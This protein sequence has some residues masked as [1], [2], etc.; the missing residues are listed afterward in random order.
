LTSSGTVNKVVTAVAPSA[1]APAPAP[2]KAAAVLKKR[3]PVTH[4][5]IAPRAAA[6][7]EASD[8]T[9]TP[10]L[11]GTNPHGQGTVAVID[12][13]PDPSRPYGG[14]T[15]GASNNEDIVV[16]RS[17]GEQRPDGTY[18]GHITVAALFGNEIVGVDTNP[19]ETK[20]GP[21]NAVQ[22]SLLDALCDG[23]GNQICLSAVTVDSTTTDTGSTNHFGVAHATLGGPTGIDVGAAESDGNI[24]SDGT[25]QT[26]T[27]SSQAA[28]V[29]AGGNA[30]ASVAKSSTTSKACK[31]QAPQQTNQSSVIQLGGT[32]VPLPAAG[33][34]D[35]TADTVTDIPTLL[36]IVCNADDT[37]G[38]QAPAPYGVREALDAFVLATGNAAL[39]KLT[40]AAAESRAV[41]PGSGG[42]GN[43]NGPEQCADGI[44]N[45]GD[46]LI[47]AADPQCHSDNNPDNPG[48]YE[49]GD[50][51]E[52]GG[53]QCSDGKDNDGDGL[54]DAKD[55]GCH[56]DGN[57]NNPDSYDANDNSEGNGNGSGSGGSGNGAQ[58]ADGIDNDGDGLIDANDPGCHSDGN[59]NN[60]SSYN[61]ND[62][63]EGGGGNAGNGNP[64]CSD[65]VDNDGDGVADSADPG[66]HSDG[67][68]NN[69][70]SYVPSDDS[71]ANGAAGVAG[72][73]ASRNASGSLPFTGEDLLGVALLGTL[74][75]AAGLGLRRLPRRRRAQ[76]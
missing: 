47:D 64:Q 7:R 22:T 1:P 16:G 8:P 14:D 38:T 19:G 44:D 29:K 24:S 13:N 49:P 33:C 72:T 76:P 40:V 27:G 45:D 6:P 30:V 70:A 43:N 54:I 61:K 39:A 57:A 15:V 75:L 73:T 35:G 3:A 21:L 48:S 10:P 11:H 23:S 41:A 17:R 26:S 32:A 65:G 62:N 20:H 2:T 63:S 36:P 58:C 68:A 9:T 71:E 50:N 4:R 46:G 28:D 66:C 53:P 51:S 55:P 34:G 69:A 25:C 18:H 31:G 12:T 74:L 5:T 37:N 56:S 42:G 59:P 52:G 60:A 67:N